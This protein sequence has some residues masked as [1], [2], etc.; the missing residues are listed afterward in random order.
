VEPP[1]GEWQLRSISQ[2][3][4]RNLR[5][6]NGSVQQPTAEPPGGKGQ[7]PTTEVRWNLLEPD[8]SSVKS[9]RRYGGN[10]GRQR[11]VSNSMDAR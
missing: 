9:H 5:E 8:G 4:R 3:V 7:G 2:E 6:A 11:E 10:S 1:V